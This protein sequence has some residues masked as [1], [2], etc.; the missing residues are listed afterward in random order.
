MLEY[1]EFWSVHNN[2]WSKVELNV[3][4]KVNNP[5]FME[6]FLGNKLPFMTHHQLSNDQALDLVVEHDF[7]DIFNYYKTLGLVTFEQLYKR[8]GKLI[9]FGSVKLLRALHGSTGENLNLQEHVTW[10]EKLPGNK[11]DWEFLKEQGY[12]Y[13]SVDKILWVACKGGHTYILDEFYEINEKLIPDTYDLEKAAIGGHWDTIKWAINNGISNEKGRLLFL[14]ILN[15]HFEFIQLFE[16]EYNYTIDS[17]STITV[18]LYGYKFIEGTKIVQTLANEAGWSARSRVIE[19]ISDKFNVLP[20]K[21]ELYGATV[22]MLKL[23]KLKK[24]EIFDADLLER[25]LQ[26]SSIKWLWDNYSHLFT[27]DVKRDWVNGCRNKK[28]LRWIH[29]N[30]KMLPQSV[31]LDVSVEDLELFIKVTG[32]E[33]DIFGVAERAVKEGNSEKVKFLIAKY[34]SY[35]KVELVSTAMA[36]GHAGIVNMLDKHFEHQFVDIQSACTYGYFEI[37][38]QSLVG[39]GASPDSI[40]WGVIYGIRNDHLEIVEYMINEGHTSAD[41]VPEYMWAAIMGDSIRIFE[42]LIKKF[43]GYKLSKDAL[44][45]C[46][47]NGSFKIFKFSLPKLSKSEL[48]M[49]LERWFDKSNYHLRIIAKEEYEKRVQGV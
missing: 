7:L 2:D 33:V 18:E 15:G 49:L 20:E 41:Q 26:M 38:K 3:M 16:S 35:L 25:I 13:V 11:E 46:W 17:K 14:A 10:L 4:Q 48:E 29:K 12:Q 8:I 24:P 43:G 23:L 34:P 28:D 31:G 5:K 42:L 19:W 6:D 44:M 40:K 30:W 22:R 1:K 9:T 36:F 32:R 39:G 45:D 21:G 27:D 37:L 47:V